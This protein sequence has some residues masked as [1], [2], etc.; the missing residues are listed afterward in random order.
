MDED[1]GTSIWA[2]ATTATSSS[3]PL[4][5]PV[6]P[7]FTQPSFDLDG[8]GEQ[9]DDSGL[10]DDDDDFGDFGEFG[11]AEGTT[12]EIGNSGHFSEPAV[13]AAGSSSWDW[14]PLQVDPHPS[15][16][17]LEAQIEEILGPLWNTDD[18]SQVLTDEDVRE[19]GGL[20]Q[21]LVTPDR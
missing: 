2:T 15:R 11:Q 3:V 4:S 16:Q 14:E 10:G 18:T 20:A 21:I 9:Q 1:F 5:S 12:E 7:T 17:T 19:V 8:F 6:Y 13:S